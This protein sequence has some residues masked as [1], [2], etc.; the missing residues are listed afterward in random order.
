LIC[1]DFL[2]DL[3]SALAD[4]WVFHWGRFERLIC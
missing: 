3:A 4:G 1:T 2:I